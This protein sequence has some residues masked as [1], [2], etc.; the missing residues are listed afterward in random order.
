MARHLQQEIEKLKGKLLALVANAKD[1][2][3]KAV[4]P[5]T[6]ATPVSHRPSSRATRKS[7][8]PRWT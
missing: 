6:N 3:E 5:S 7:T 2:V 8:A 4:S 1:A